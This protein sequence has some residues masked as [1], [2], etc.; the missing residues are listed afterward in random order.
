MSKLLGIVGI[1]TFFNPQTIIRSILGKRLR[2]PE[3]DCD[4]EDRVVSKRRAPLFEI[5]RLPP[6]LRDEIWSA[7]FTPQT[8]L[9]R[10][11]AP[12]ELGFPF[13]YDVEMQ[14]LYQHPKTLGINRDSRN[15]TLR[16]YHRILV[17]EIPDSFFYFNPEIDTLALNSD[18][19]FDSGDA[20]QALIEET[21]SDD[22][23]AN[24]APFESMRKLKELLHAK[25]PITG[26]TNN[27]DKL[28]R[29][30]IGGFYW[31]QFLEEPD[32]YAGWFQY[33]FEDQVEVGFRN[34]KELTFVLLDEADEIKPKEHDDF[35]LLNLRCP[36]D[37]Q[38]C[39]KDIQAMFE[40]EREFVP[41]CRVPEICFL[42]NWMDLKN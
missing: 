37:Q 34:L 2:E 35:R 16:H 39:R 15:E 7:S 6:E 22:L 11:R 26:M 42:E 4:I 24:L 18:F 31:L 8:L 27:L 20:S 25:S 9:L 17:N 40:R 1:P 3:D 36:E 41:D 10:L 5:S 38:I 30:V 33:H 21:G 12:V 14:S 28:Q 32:S 13:Q 23:S 19:V 29:L